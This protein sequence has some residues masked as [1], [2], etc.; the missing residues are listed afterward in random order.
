MPNGSLKILIEG[1][2]RAKITGLNST[3][4]NFLLIDYDKIA[5]TQESSDAELEAAWRQLDT[6][7][8]NYTKSNQKVPTDMT[9][10]ARDFK[11]RD[12]ITDTIAVHANLSFQ[13]R[14]K[15]LETVDLTSRMIDLAIL[16]KNEIDILQVEQR[17]KGRIQ[18]QVE[19]NQREY[20]LTE[21]IK[22]IHK[23]LGREDQL[24][25]INELRNQ[26]KTLKLPAHVAEKAEKELH[27]LEQM[28]GMSAEAAV[29]KN[30]LDWLINLPW[31]KLSKDSIS[32]KQAETMLEKQHAGLKKAKERIIEF[33]AAK[34][35]A[36]DL[37]RSPIIC[38]A[39][40]PGVGKTSLASSI[41]DTLWPR[42]SASSRIPPREARTNSRPRAL[43][44][45]LP[46]EV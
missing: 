20:Y 24:E 46:M 37:K 43:A 32:L 16:L 21:Q 27:R 15:I 14:Q 12:T 9:A 23:E 19:K 33:I 45:D 7:Y 10:L 8:Q 35:F 6:I 5:S 18:D 42:I 28:P 29:S 40:A 30:Y 38:L 26:I 11:D 34:K 3:N 44:I 17:I 13:D 36:K 39:G 31:H 41:A 2:Q 25:E 4:N 1:I 22:A